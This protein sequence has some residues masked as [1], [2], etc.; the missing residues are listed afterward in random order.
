MVIN[1]MAII[2]TNGCSIDVKRRVALLI[3]PSA[4]KPNGE[5]KYTTKP[6]TNW[7]CE[8]IKAISEKVLSFEANS[9]LENTPKNELITTT[10][11]EISV[12]NAHQEW[13][14]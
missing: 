11:S 3:C 6:N 10:K 12:I 5:R 9:L 14:V 13:S 4:L 8:K 7:M 2:P 1:M